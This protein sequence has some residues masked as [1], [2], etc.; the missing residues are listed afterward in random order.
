[1]KCGLE[2]NIGE[3][4]SQLVLKQGW[5]AIFTSESQSALAKVLKF[6]NADMEKTKKHPQKKKGFYVHCETIL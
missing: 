6:A 2:N 3:N 4:L 5:P 1:M